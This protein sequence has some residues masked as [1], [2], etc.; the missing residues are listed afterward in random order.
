MQDAINAVLNFLQAILRLPDRNIRP[1]L[2]Y[3]LSYFI[4]QVIDDSQK[5]RDQRR[6]HSLDLHKIIEFFNNHD[7]YT[8]TAEKTI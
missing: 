3:Q 7:S 5:K 6:I 4:F 2:R 1:F 8:L